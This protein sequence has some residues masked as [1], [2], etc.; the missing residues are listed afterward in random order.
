M[1][2]FA[3]TDI[4]LFDQPKAWLETHGINILIIL[5][6]AWVLRRVGVAV[7]TGLFKPA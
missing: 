1:S 2:I 3:V 7:I 5:V 6:G 4:T